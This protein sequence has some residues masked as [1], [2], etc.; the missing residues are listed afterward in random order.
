MTENVILSIGSV[1][2]L[3]EIRSSRSSLN[4]MQVFDDDFLH[5]NESLEEFRSRLRIRRSIKARDKDWNTYQENEGDRSDFSYDSTTKEAHEEILRNAESLRLEQV[6]HRFGVSQSKAYQLLSL[7]TFRI[8]HFLSDNRHIYY[9]TVFWQNSLW[10]YNLLPVMIN[11]NSF[12]NSD[13]FF[14]NSNWMI[15]F[16]A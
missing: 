10:N 14:L 11:E 3:D 16:G 9:F 6:R 13:K 1:R 8:K 2:K 15:A 5:K 12:S 7:Q 4:K